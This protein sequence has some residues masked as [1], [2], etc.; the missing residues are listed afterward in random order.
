MRDD[1][2]VMSCFPLHF[3][4]AATMPLSVG[5]TYLFECAVRLPLRL[6]SVR[7]HL[8]FALNWLLYFEK[9]S[10]DADPSLKCLCRSMSLTLRTTRFRHLIDQQ[11]ND[12]SNEVQVNRKEAFEVRA[13][14]SDRLNMTLIAQLTRLYNDPRAFRRSGDKPWRVSFV[15]ESAIDAGGPAR[16]L[17]T[18]AAADALAPACGLFV[19]TPNGRNEVGANR[20]FVIPC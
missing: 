12:D 11:S 8:L 19:P 4:S 2:K 9:I 15:N 14:A 16:E 18:E 3:F 17:V 5:P 1:E 7:A 13:G 20:E 6:L 10:F